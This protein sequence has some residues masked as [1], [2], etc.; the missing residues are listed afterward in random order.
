M[1]ENF[2]LALLQPQTLSPSRH[3]IPVAS[4]L[5]IINKIFCCLGATKNAPVSQIQQTRSFCHPEDL[6]IP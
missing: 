3:K 1:R 6:K 2:H 5:S 4:Q